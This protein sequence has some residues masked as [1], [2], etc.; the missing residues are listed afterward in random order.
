MRK[1]FGGRTFSVDCLLAGLRWNPANRQSTKILSARDMRISQQCS[2]RFMH[3]GMCHSFGR[4]S[5]G[6][7]PLS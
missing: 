1:L 6:I 2:W 5:H 4:F 7:L 3:F